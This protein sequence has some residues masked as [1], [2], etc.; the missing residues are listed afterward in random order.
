MEIVSWRERDRRR[1]ILKMKPDIQRQA[2]RIKMQLLMSAVR[3]TSAEI[4]KVPVVRRWFPKSSL[5]LASRSHKVGSIERF[6]TYFFDTS[7][8]LSSESVHSFPSY[9]PI[10]M[11]LQT[12]P[13]LPKTYILFSTLKFAVPCPVIRA[14]Y[15][16]GLLHP[17]TRLLS[18]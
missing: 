17:F 3:I 14:S 11:S 2:Y 18:L 9:P 8:S 12:S 10:A 6:E 13:C 7:Q 15:P 5:P 1:K 16:V 4:I